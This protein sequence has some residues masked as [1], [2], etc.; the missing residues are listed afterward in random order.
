MEPES[1]PP[2]EDVPETPPTEPAPPPAGVPPPEPPI[3]AP[4]EPGA[5]GEAPPAEKPRKEP[6]KPKKRP[7]YE[8]KL[9]GKYDMTDVAVRDAGRGRAAPRP[10]R[11]R[12]SEH[13]EGC[14]LGDVQEPQAG[15]GVPRGRD[16]HGGERRHAELCDRKEGGARGG[17]VVPAMRTCDRR[18]RLRGADRRLAREARISSAGTEPPSQ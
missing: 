13:Q 15:R 2:P 7:S 17:R 14:G 10:A 1:P 12:A 8:M 18:R 16:P 11:P 9:F 5:E 6:K 4:P 3:E